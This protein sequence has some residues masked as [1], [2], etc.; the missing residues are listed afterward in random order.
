M[1]IL[2]FIFLLKPFSYLIER[3]LPGSEKVLPIWPIFLDERCLTKAEDALECVRKELLRQFVL[4]QKMFSESLNLILNF[5]Q[6]KRRDI[7]YI[8]LIVDNIQVEIYRYLCKIPSSYL[9][10]ELSNKIFAFTGMVGDIERIADHCVNLSNLSKNR[11]QTKTTFSEIAKVELAEVEKLVSENLNDAITLIE[12]RNEEKIR[13]IFER[14]EE[15]DLKIREVTERHLE[16][17]HKGL[18]QGA[19]GPIFV[20][21]LLNLERISDHCENIAEYIEVLNGK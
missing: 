16:R 11:Y 4:A 15:V 5:S 13:M 10:A 19:T 9:S 3:I 2:I 6:I 21:M 18:C 20:E 14:E 12:K 17:F 7:L 8:E 1:I